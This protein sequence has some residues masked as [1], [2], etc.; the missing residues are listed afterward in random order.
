MA[1]IRPSLILR[2]DIDER[3]YNEELVGMI[4][5]SY[6]Y[7]GASKITSHEPAAEDAENV[8]RYDIKLHKPYWDKN[9]PEAAAQWDEV[10]P[11]WLHNMF[12]KVGTTIVFTNKEAER[13]FMKPLY[14]SWTELQFGSNVI[15]AFKT[16][17]DSTLDDSYIGMVEQAR[18]L[19]SDGVL[20]EGVEVIRVPS[21]ASYE[22]QK[23][24]IIEERRRKADEEVAAAAAAAVEA[25]AAAAAAAA[26]E[27]EA[28]AAI[29]DFFD[30]ELEAVE[31]EAAETPKAETAEEAE[32]PEAKAE[33]EREGE[34]AESE[35]E[36]EEEPEEE[37]EPEPEVIVEH[38]NFTPDTTIWGIEYA[39]GTVREFNSAT[40][41]FV[42]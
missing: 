8:L 22:A 11:Q 21:R 16:R 2:A 9:D 38:I 17:E 37:P 39:D 23:A 15:M 42:D 14:Y 18:A 28:K 27:A 5:R 29:D 24:A 40:E 12:Y 35:E 4:K 10:I 36:L 33:D 41:A 19:M 3:E 30:E 6:A 34:E 20:G 32:Q 26:A 25:E 1:R 31:P 7:I 13:N